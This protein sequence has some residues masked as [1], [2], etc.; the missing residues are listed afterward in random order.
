MSDEIVFTQSKHFKAM[1]EKDLLSLYQRISMK[2]KANSQ[3]YAKLGMDD[4]NVAFKSGISTVSSRLRMTID[5]ANNASRDVEGR[6]YVIC[7]LGSLFAAAEA[8]EALFNWYPSHFKEG[9]WVSES[10]EL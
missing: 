6:N 10:D 1:S 2:L 7:V 8:R 4:T 9:D 3:K 5:E